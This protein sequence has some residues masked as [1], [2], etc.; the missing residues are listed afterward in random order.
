MVMR[1]NSRIWGYPDSK[2]QVPK[3]PG[4]PAF[5]STGPWWASWRREEEEE[6]GCSGGLL[7][8]WS[9]LGFP[10]AS[11]LY[12]ACSLWVDDQVD[13]WLSFPLPLRRFY[14]M[15]TWSPSYQQAVQLVR[16]K[17]SKSCSLQT[18]SSHTPCSHPHPKVDKRGQVCRRRA[19]GPVSID[20][21][22]EREPQSLLQALVLTLALSSPAFL[23]R[24]G[25]MA[26]YGGG[27]TGPLA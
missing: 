17:V 12:Q 18:L 21:A 11:T 5:L 1:P 8:L 10:P 7:K 13:M 23:H 6:A 15:A 4:Y 25:P 9:E 16:H 27:G 2:S 14:W 20:S 22:S 3:I 24:H 19:T 26:W